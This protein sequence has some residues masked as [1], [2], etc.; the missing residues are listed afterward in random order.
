MLVVFSTQNQKKLINLQFDFKI[1]N[2]LYLLIQ[3]KVNFQ[4]QL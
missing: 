3:F 1:K 2:I 4:K